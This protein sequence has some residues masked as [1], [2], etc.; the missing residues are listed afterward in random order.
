M[1]RLM[2]GATCGFGGRA[3]AISGK[4]YLLAVKCEQID[5]KRLG[6]HTV[7]KS[8][9]S[10]G[11]SP[12]AAANGAEG[13]D[14]V[15]PNPRKLPM[16]DSRDMGLNELPRL[17][18]ESRRAGLVAAAPVTGV[19]ALAVD[20]ASSSPRALRELRELSA[21]GS[22]DVALR[23]ASTDSILSSLLSLVS[24]PSLLAALVDMLRLE[25][26]R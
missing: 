1:K 18:T 6:R 2:G 10:A 15:R 7:A 23:P 25:M 3:A 14:A 11:F 26:R 13:V 20:A 16:L 12:A 9:P 5:K 17:R 8:T 21:L 24:F 4:A 22:R 19:E